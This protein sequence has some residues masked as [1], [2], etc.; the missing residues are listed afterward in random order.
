MTPG[1]GM[2]D[3]W[4]PEEAAAR[5]Q[6]GGGGGHQ[7]RDVRA[8]QEAE[9]RAQGDHERGKIEIISSD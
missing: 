6:G 4:W 2:D 8:G 9:Q 5:D 7:G 3:G 1:P